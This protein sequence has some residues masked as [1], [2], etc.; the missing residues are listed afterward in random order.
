MSFPSSQI[1]QGQT[2]K[3]PFQ[4]QTVLLPT[5]WARWHRHGWLYPVLGLRRFKSYDGPVTASYSSP[6][7]YIYVTHACPCKGTEGSGNPLQLA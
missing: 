5:A 6:V 7:L 1:K 2:D 4:V 3:Q